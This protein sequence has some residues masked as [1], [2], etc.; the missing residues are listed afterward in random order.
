MPTPPPAA[1]YS[2]KPLAAKLG[3]AAGMAAAVID[4]PAHYSALLGD[5][6]APGKLGRGEYLFI[7]LFA[8]DR[9]TLVKHLPRAIEQL[10][11]HGAIWVSWPKKTSLLFKDLTENSIREIAL[12]LGVVDVKV[13]AVDADW[14]GLKLMRRTGKT[15]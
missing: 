12:P 7:H 1:G 5:V 2:G 15:K 4:P 9:T 8:A 11:P 6:P 3:L 14:S 10:A 13:C